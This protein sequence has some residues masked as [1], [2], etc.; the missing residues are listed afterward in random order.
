MKSL[1]LTHEQL[2]ELGFDFSKK[3]PGSRNATGNKEVVS[4]EG[5]G[6]KRRGSSQDELLQFEDAFGEDDWIDG[7]S[8]DNDAPAQP[9]SHDSN[10][11]WSEVNVRAITFTWSHSFLK[12]KTRPIK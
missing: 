10:L 4:Q 11:A 1:T 2:E 7:D 9:E 3:E 8:S 5:D 6:L 12:T